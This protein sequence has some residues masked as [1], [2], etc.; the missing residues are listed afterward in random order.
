[1]TY[2]KI[3]FG[4]QWDSRQ[5]VKV[6]RKKIHDS[7][8]AKT[9]DDYLG[10]ESD[11]NSAEV[12]KPLNK[13]NLFSD[14]KSELDLA[15]TIQVLCG[16]DLSRIKR[17]IHEIKNYS[18]MY[19]LNKFGLSGLQNDEEVLAQNLG[20]QFIEA[21]T[22]LKRLNSSVGKFTYRDKSNMHFDVEVSLPYWSVLKPDGTIDKVPVNKQNYN[23]SPR[24]K[25]AIRDINRTEKGELIFN[26]NERVK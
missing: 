21:M 8:K 10:V 12:E 19:G 14:I 1:M 3:K 18:E 13:D 4:R 6:F 17:I 22:R 15:K 11:E 5:R 7:I 26:G 20:F 23:N 25:G 16:G 9:I 2:F 24:P